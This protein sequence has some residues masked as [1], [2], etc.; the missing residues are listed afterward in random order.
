M[1]MRRLRHAALENG[2]YILRKDG[3]GQTA[4]M[5]LQPAILGMRASCEVADQG[6]PPCVPTNTRPFIKRKRA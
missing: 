3:A 5:A 6:N 4:R 2:V 1:T